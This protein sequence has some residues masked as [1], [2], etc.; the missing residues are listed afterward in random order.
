MLAC[1]DKTQVD[2][3]WL[4]DDNLAPSGAARRAGG[5]SCLTSPIIATSP[6]RLNWQNWAQHWPESG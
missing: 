1:A 3:D 6:A 2:G 4:I 5:I